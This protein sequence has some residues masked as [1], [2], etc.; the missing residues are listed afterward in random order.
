M[1]DF[2]IKGKRGLT[3]LHY[4]LQK[5]VQEASMFLLDQ[6]N[7]SKKGEPMVN[8]FARDS[9]MRLPRH[10]TIINSLIYKMILHQELNISHKI[11]CSY[12]HCKKNILYDQYENTTLFKGNTIQGR[13]NTIEK[14]ID[15]NSRM[16]PRQLKSFLQESHQ[17]EDR[18]YILS[19]P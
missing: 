13:N 6:E 9:L 17:K 8:V 16:D 14:A 12:K 18:K 11:A 2:N 10:L 7:L 4:G 5:N 19:K 15:F 3:P 1:F